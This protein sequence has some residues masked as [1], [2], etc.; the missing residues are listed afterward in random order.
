M[1]GSE[2]E[3]MRSI[4]RCLSGARWSGL[5]GGASARSSK[6]SVAGAV[7]WMALG[8]VAAAEPCSPLGSGATLDEIVRHVT[9]QGLKYVFV[10]E[11]HE[12]GPPKRLAVDLGNALVDLGH[13]VGLYVEGFR[14]GC[15]L[16]DAAC[17]KLARLFNDAAFAALLAESRAPVRPLDPPQ[18]DRR[19]TRM[20]ATIREGSEAVRIVLVGNSHVVH[21]TVAE[22]EHWV[23]GGGL[24]YPDP[25][26]LVEAFPREESLTLILETAEDGIAPYSLSA[27]GCEADYRVLAPATGAY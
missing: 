25:G 4:H 9:D 1:M 24:R 27:D 12:S 10:G 5:L 22:A 19:A 6:L 26:D 3:A 20:A 8:S 18:R 23:F 7:C 17:H 21:A 15:A 11:S 14:I 16:D 13:D 2:E